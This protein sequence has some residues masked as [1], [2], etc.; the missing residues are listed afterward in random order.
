METSFKIARHSVF[1]SM[2]IVEIL[3]DGKVAG[4]IYPAGEKQIKIISAHIEKTEVEEGFAGE[5]IDVKD[6]GGGPPI[7]AFT[8]K[9]NPTPYMIRGNKIIKL[10]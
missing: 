6:K 4:V 9:F 5:V 8:V 10:P 2:P 1:P 3:I 7:P